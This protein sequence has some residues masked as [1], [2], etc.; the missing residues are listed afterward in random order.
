VKYLLLGSAVLVA[1][2]GTF[3]LFNGLSYRSVVPR[4]GS[5]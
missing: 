4:D 1:C 5:P 2:L 3:V